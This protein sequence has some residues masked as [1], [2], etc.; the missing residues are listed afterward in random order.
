MNERPGPD[1]GQ[2][3]E[4]VPAH[5][6]AGTI[7]SVPRQQRRAP[8]DA[9]HTHEAPDPAAH[10]GAPGPYDHLPS[11]DHDPLDHPDPAV[12]ADAAGI[13]HL[14]RCWIR[15]SGTPRPAEG[16]VRIPLRAAAGALHLPVRYWSPTGWHRLGAPTLEGAPAG[17]APWTPSPSPRC[18]AGRPRTA[19]AGPPTA[20][21]TGWRT[22][23]SG[24]LRTPNGSRPRTAP[25]PNSSAGS[26]TPYGTS[27]PSSPTGG[28]GPPTTTAPSSSK[29]NSPCSS[30]TRCTPHP[31]AARA[32]P[33]PRPGPIRPNSAAP[34]RSTGRPCTAPSWP[35]TPPGPNAAS[36]Y[37]PSSSP[38]TSRATASD[39]PTTPC[40]CRCT[41]AGQG[42][43]RPRRHRGPP[44]GR[45]AARPRGPRP[46]LA[47]HLLRPHG[48]PPR[49]ERHAEALPRAADHQLPPGEPP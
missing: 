27:P 3:A 26:P 5:Q 12:A 14:L 40:R 15:E 46:A 43:R 9:C 38:G 19:T 7:E 47:P 32:S 16:G 45:P 10:H 1:G 41:L 11:G 37:R 49:R 24:R 34:S 21:S 20:A 42:A 28:P 2:S 30:A 35:P 13:E 29:P 6:G 44:R 31:R 36:P 23:T 8:G 4:R 33:M 22:P 39:S 25:V 18:C 48:L 17:A